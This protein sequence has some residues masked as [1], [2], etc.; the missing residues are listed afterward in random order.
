VYERQLVL[1]DLQVQQVCVLQ[2]VLQ[3]V[4]QWTLQ[5]V[6]P[7]VGTTVVEYVFEEV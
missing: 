1:M 7:C 6:L 5:W 2:C 4:L 3:W